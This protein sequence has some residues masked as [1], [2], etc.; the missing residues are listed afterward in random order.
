[1]YRDIPANG[2]DIREILIE[3]PLDGYELLDFGK[4]RKLERFGPYVLD[5]PETRAAGT[6]ARDAWSADWTFVEHRTGRGDWQAARAGLPRQWDLALDGMTTRCAL[7]DKGRI[8]VNP[9]DVATRRWVRQRLEGCYDMEDLSALILFA[10]SG[11]TTDAAIQAGAEVTHVEGSAEVLDLARHNLGTDN[12]RFEQLDVQAF[13]EGATRRGERFDFVLISPPRIGRVQAGVSWDI[14]VDLA[15]L[16]RNL[17]S[18]VSD[19]CRGIWVNVDAGSWSSPSIAQMLRDALPGC[20]VEA[21]KLGIVTADGRIMP[22]GGAAFWF[23]EFDYLHGNASLP[24]LMAAQ[25]EEYLDIHLDAVLSSRRSAT[26]PALRLEGFDRTQQDFVLHWVGV[27]AHTNAEMAYQFAYYAGNALRLMDETGVEAWL[28][29]AMDVFDTAGLHAGIAVLQ[30][31]ENFADQLRERT[32][33][34]PFDEVANVLEAFVRGLSGRPLKVESADHH[35]TDTETLFLPPLINRFAERGANFQIFKAMACHLWAQTWYGTWR[36]DVNELVNRFADPGHALRVFHA[37]E[38]IRLDARLADD[39][40]GMY[41]QMRELCE[42]NDE[43][44]GV[45]WQ[46]ARCTLWAADATVEDSCRLMRHLYDSPLPAPAPYQGRLDPLRVQRVRNARIF[47]EKDLFRRCLLRIQDELQRQTEA[48]EGGV[49]SP[50]DA[51]SGKK[52]GFGVHE[53]V[54]SD[55]P[56]GVTFELTLDGKPIAPPDDV[57]GTMESILQDLGEIPEDYL[58]AAGDGPYHPG[59]P[60]AEDQDPS[61]VWKGVY[62]EEGAYLYNEWDYERQHYR[63]KWAVLRELEVRPQ[64]DDFA[65]KTLTKYRGLVRDL[66]RTFEALRGEDKLLKKQVNGDDVD[67][68][69]LVEAY[70]DTRAGMEMNDR[71]F[72]KMRKLE[73]NIAVMFMVDM[74]GSTKGWINDAEREALVLLCESLETLGDR[75]A[76]YG[77]SGMTRKR[78]EIYRVKA[79]EDPYDDQVKGRISGISPQDY[80]RMGVTIRHLSRL[81]NEVDARTRLLITLSDGKPDDYD[82]YRGT[83][84]IEDTRQALIEAKREGIHPF[85]ITIDTESRDYLTHMYGAVNFTVI[86]EVRQL[87]LKVSDIY[88]RLT[89]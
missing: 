50:E 88:R 34:L 54:S 39:L 33:G 10:G 45:G 1:M 78:C 35:Y 28:I 27:I 41:R 29:K 51:P 19:Q 23:N 40:P 60:A 30:N 6:P 74:S 64:Y 85:C 4:G 84:G 81:L 32:S 17:P 67:I 46:D 77:F 47:Y 26:E 15:R 38:R 49:N 71:L 72:T 36:I 14:E 2:S 66:R 37:L 63:K 70:A 42:G 7:G 73:R 52:S 3:T 87:P 22:A 58:F 5:R 21:V 68:D 44:P 53:M 48:E 79:F 59:V 8:G 86:D 56:D 13:I 89:T 61:D 12:A 57:K 31:V 62:H 55:K 25:L 11:T 69:A 65:A 83:Y 18:I 82:N 43:L 9:R 16:I 80:T 24:S 75:Y 76:I 20:T